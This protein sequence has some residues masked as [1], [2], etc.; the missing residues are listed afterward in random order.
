MR[1]I[2]L[3]TV[4]LSL[5]SC[6]HLYGFLSVKRALAPGPK[7]N[8]AVILFMVLM[9]FAP[10][11]VRFLERNDL[12]TP[13]R[14]FAYI[15]Y[16]WMG[17]L[18]LFFSFA[19]AFDAYRV[20]L[21]VIQRPFNVDLAR[22]SL[23]K[24]QCFIIPLFL[25]VG[26]TIFGF[27]EALNIR[28][29]RVVIR[30]DKITQQIGRLKI[31]QISDVHLGLIVGK[32]RLKKI[33]ELV[34]AEK[35]DLLVSTGDLVHGQMNKLSELTEMIREIPTKYGKY[36][37][38]GN[39]EF[40]AGLQ[41]ALKVTTDAGFRVLRGEGHNI[42]GVINIAGVDDPAGKRFG[43]EG[44]VSEK[45]LLSKLPRE[46]FTLFLKHRPRFNKA[47]GEL[48]DLQL[49]GH[50]HKGQIFPLSM[51]VK[52]FYPYFNGLVSLG[53]NSYIYVSRGTG[54]WGPPVR[55]LSPPE[56]TVI[57]LVHEIKTNHQA[58]KL[59]NS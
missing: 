30:T 50:T 31:V 11:I 38:T 41:E 15:G 19:V 44:N 36:A 46:N 33:L 12:V 18:F 21:E 58:S 34:K 4:F 20:I 56:V 8:T 35:P 48:F 25:S 10:I 24:V 29:E 17:L 39:H 42:P 6:L 13:A 59:Q 9:I 1:Y 45:V 32:H 26:I 5:Y 22:F 53:N 3:L 14:F 2:I 52:L 40:Y 37:V 43:L 55:F 28:T 23:S 51:I 47:E 49:S 27:F 54:T 7:A 57:E 16:I